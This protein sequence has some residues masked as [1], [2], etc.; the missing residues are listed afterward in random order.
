MKR[1]LR[2]SLDA[3]ISS[4]ITT[5][6]WF[7]L[8]IFVEKNII[9]I[10]ILIYPIYHV[11][12]I[13]KSIFA[14]GA[15]I[16]SQKGNKDDVLSGITFGIIFSII[17][18]GLI[19]INIKYYINFM[20]INVSNC[21]VIYAIIQI[22][23]Q[24]ILNFVI[25]KLYYEN[26]NKVANKYSIIFYLL[27]F[28]CILLTSLIFKKKLY[29]IIPTVFALSIFI[30]YILIKSYKKFKLKLN[31]LSWIKFDSVRLVDNIFLGL[32]YFFG[33]GIAVNFGESYALA[34]TFVALITDTQWD[35]VNSSIPE[36]AKI[37]ISKK[38]FDY[39][40]HLKNA[41]KLM[42]IILISIIILLLTLYRYYDLN[43]TVTLIYL[44]FHFLDFLIY[45]VYVLKTVYLQLEYSTIKTNFNNLIARILRLI[46]SFLKT[47]FCTVIAQVSSAIYQLFSVNFMYK[48]NIINKMSKIC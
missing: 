11:S 30:I 1:L 46:L 22:F 16:S 24:T 17:S 13:L 41:Y 15:N 19:L 9:N 39:K 25:V 7:V 28:V 3:L 43:M 44:A 18:F 38:V 5:L 23:L 14:I 4:L 40:T 34:M 8:S 48:K 27:N 12:G 47:P 29:I 32:G 35:I 45:P 42:S 6:I 20:G 37:D 31:L 10:F 36:V 26:K 21:F 33:I 2:V